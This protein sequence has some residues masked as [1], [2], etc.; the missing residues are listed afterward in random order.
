[1][2]ILWDQGHSDVVLS[3]PDLGNIKEHRERVSLKQGL[4]LGVRHV[5]MLTV[6]LALENLVV[7]ERNRTE[8]TFHKGPGTCNRL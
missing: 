6:S 5:E 8:I 1:M 4:K 7:L 3:G 2:G